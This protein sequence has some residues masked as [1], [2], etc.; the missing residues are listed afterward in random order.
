MRPCDMVSQRFR[1]TKCLCISQSSL[2]TP[3][4]PAEMAFWFLLMSQ[5]SWS[6]PF[7][8]IYC[9]LL[10]SSV[11][12]HLAIFFLTGFLHYNE[13]VISGTQPEELGQPL[14][15]EYKRHQLRAFHLGSGRNTK[16]KQIISY[17]RELWS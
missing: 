11:T 14:K 13:S 16:D 9:V 7:V 12:P 1:P 8:L 3:L 10:F 6:G 17:Q 4:T 5:L 2:F 15:T